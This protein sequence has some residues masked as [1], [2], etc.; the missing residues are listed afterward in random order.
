MKSSSSRGGTSARSLLLTLAA[1][2]C[3]RCVATMLSLAL[4][5]ALAG[6]DASRMPFDL[7]GPISLPDDPEALAAIELSAKEHDEHH[8]MLCKYQYCGPVDKVEP[9]EY[10]VYPTGMPSV[11]YPEA[12]A[13]A[14]VYV[15][16]TPLFSAEEM[17]R[18]IDLAEQEGIATRDDPTQAARASMKY[19]A[20]G[21]VAIGTKI[22]L[23]PSVNKWFNKACKTALFPHM[24]ALF[25]KM[26]SDGSKLRAHTIAVLKYNTSHPRTDVHVDPS[27]FA[28][29]I[30]LQPAESVAWPLLGMHRWCLSRRWP[31]PRSPARRLGSSEA[32]G[33]LNSPPRACA[34]RATP[35]RLSPPPPGSLQGERL[36]GRRHVLRAH[37]SRGRHG[38]GPRHLPPRLRPSRGFRHLLWA[39]LHHRGLHRRRRPVRPWPRP[40]R[41]RAAAPPSASVTTV[42]LSAPSPSLATLVA[43][44]RARQDRARAPPQ[45]PRQQDGGPQRTGHH[46]RRPGARDAPLPGTLLTSTHLRRTTF[47]CSHT[48]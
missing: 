24:A 33:G 14:E 30:A 13:D 1:M 15:S 3:R 19:G 18:V 2:A 41:H 11:D 48:P 26:I 31:S 47:P 21:Q 4:P 5:A 10:D 36:R 40:P 35:S 39:A 44:R 29:T 12:L 37:R 25:P 34:P 32:C 6:L 16:K 7:H 46:R 9:L 27:L 45:R 22:E 17:D 38:A 20:A 42:A 23:M 43:T 8:A 28:F